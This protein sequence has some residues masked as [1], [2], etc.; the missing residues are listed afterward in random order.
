M[1]EDKLTIKD[2]IENI[3]EAGINAIPVV[4]G[5]LN[6]LYFGRK[7]E[8][9]FKRIEKFYELLKDDFESIQDKVSEALEKL[10]HNSLT[11]IIEEINENVEKDYL[12]S[13]LNYFKNC[14]YN[15]LI[16][17][18]SDS[19]GK[20]K[21]FIDVLGKLTDMD[22]QIIHNLYQAQRD[23]GY[24]PEL[25]SEHENNSEFIGSLEKLKSY[26]LV[27]SKL[28]GTLKPGIN[29]SEITLYIISDFGRDFVEYCLQINK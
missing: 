4:G 16:S 19:Y 12:E 21:Y 6:T 2:N 1:E 28:N 27:H 10:D 15:S 17:Q 24:T 3:V 7:Q 22:I 11:G 26:G 9:R 13:K 14:F 25:E 29:W 20:R 23:H 8:K 18:D 5:S